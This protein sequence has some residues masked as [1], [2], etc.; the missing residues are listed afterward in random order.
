MS[1]TSHGWTC[2]PRSLLILVIICLRILIVDNPRTPPPSSGLSASFTMHRLDSPTQRQKTQWFFHGEGGRTHKKP[3]TQWPPGP[4][5]RFP[6][7]DR[8]EEDG[9]AASSASSPGVSV[10]IAQTDVST[11]PKTGRP[12]TS[13]EKHIV[14]NVRLGGWKCVLSRHLLRGLF[15]LLVHVTKRARLLLR[16]R[17]VFPA[18]NITLESSS[19][20]YLQHWN[21]TLPMSQWGCANSPFTQNVESTLVGGQVSL[22][23]TRGTPTASGLGTSTGSTSS[24]SSSSTSSSLSTAEITGIAVGSVIFLAL[25]LGALKHMLRPKDADAPKLS[26]DY[27]LQPTN[28]APPPGPPPPGPHVVNNYYTHPT[29][30]P[31]YNASPDSR[32]YF[33]QSPHALSPENLDRLQSGYSDRSPRTVDSVSVIDRYSNVGDLPEF[34]HSPRNNYPMSQAPPS[35]I[36]APPQRLPPI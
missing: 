19:Y 1:N 18:Y 14:D 9:D 17:R 7:E 29:S 22:T 10:A 36:S 21:G 3:P 25:I 2:R 4:W 15:V 28:Y 35:E 5:S 26:A 12:P 34:R 31:P 16:S 11:R 6:K 27:P 8:R 13:G 23:T 20:C 33:G 30:P 32:E 24:T